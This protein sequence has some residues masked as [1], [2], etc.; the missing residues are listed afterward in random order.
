MNERKHLLLCVAGMTPQI[1]T[2]TLYALT[3]EQGEREALRFGLRVLP[4]RL[5]WA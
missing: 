5:A 4:E 1:V 3:E 2:E